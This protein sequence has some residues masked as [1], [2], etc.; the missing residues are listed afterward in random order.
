MGTIAQKKLRSQ[1]QVVKREGK[2]VERRGERIDPEE[3]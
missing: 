3:F 2:D 1:A